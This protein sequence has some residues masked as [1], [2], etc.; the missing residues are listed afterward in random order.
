MFV[1]NTS[2]ILF[3][4]FSEFN[5]NI[6]DAI[7]N[8]V[9]HFVRYLYFIQKTEQMSST[10]LRFFVILGTFYRDELDRNY[11]LPHPCNMSRPS[12]H[13]KKCSFNVCIEHFKT[14]VTYLTKNHILS[15][16]YHITL[17]IYSLKLTRQIP[18]SIIQQWKDCP[19]FEKYD[20]FS[21]GQR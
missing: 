15:M 6:T 9:S 7:E 3:Q 17:R 1:K 2:D 8:G 4:T 10:F 18:V 16:Q 21:L 11:D 13:Y 14:Y 12:Q 19:F 20:I 5:E